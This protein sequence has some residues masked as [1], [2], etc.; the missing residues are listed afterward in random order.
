MAKKYELVGISGVLLG[1]RFPL[2]PGKPVK[3]GRAQDGINVP[4]NHVSLRHAEVSLDNDEIWLRDLG[5][6]TGTIA[7]GERIGEE[8]VKVESGTELELGATHFLI[9]E[10]DQVPRTVYVVLGCMTL[11][12]SAL[13]YTGYRASLPIEYAPSLA[14]PAEVTVGPNTVVT[15]LALPSDV[16]RVLGK[17][18]R[19]L[20]IAQITD[21]NGDGISEV[22]LAAKGLQAPYTFADDG[23]WVSLGTLKGECVAG[24]GSGFPDFNC[25]GTTW[26]FA[27]N[28][29]GPS[30]QKGVVAW[31]RGLPQE[32]P[33][34]KDGEAPPAKP[35]NVPRP[36]RMSLLD[37]Q[38]FAGFLA[39]RGIR[40]PIHYLVCED[41]IPGSQ[42]QVL[43]Q[44]G[45]L[46]AMSKGCIRQMRISGPDS[47]KVQ[48]EL[49]VAFAFTPA[50][51]EALIADVTTTLGG[52]PD[53]QFIARSD[54]ARMA[55]F[56]APPEDKIGSLRVAFEAVEDSFRAI[57][58]NAPVAGYRGLLPLK[59]TPPPRL[60]VGARPTTSGVFT[61][62]PP[63]CSVLEVDVK[64]W[65]CPRRRLCRS[66]NTFVQVRETG[67]EGGGVVTEAG[68][69]AGR[70]GA[71]TEHVEVRVD[72]SS[73]DDGSQVDVTSALVS[74]R[75]PLA[76]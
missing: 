41:A 33:T 5:S 39:E 47:A 4:D 14:A 67:C 37:P 72:V 74:Y 19:Q 51:Y 58:N 15:Q 52:S 23:S 62:D 3:I 1:E 61:L 55:A 53:A 6:Q 28:T 8:P 66:G 21:H 60:A 25:S 27:N 24:K 2:E 68:Y 45:E 38:R 76:K 59:G 49:P 16:I 34:A 40:E 73:F 56:V 70:Y 10:R 20:K 64:S 36:A 17:D 35:P 42:P 32:A 50:G 11:V 30:A 48:G 54:R 13:G 7:N 31:I 63:G 65:H 69:G 46:K 57:A 26:S 71:S 44:R 18:H 22:W 12:L 9:E 29:Y 75:M 43:T